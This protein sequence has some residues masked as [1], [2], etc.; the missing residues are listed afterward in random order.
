MEGD[1]LISKHIVLP[2]LINGV[3]TSALYDPGSNASFISASFARKHHITAIPLEKPKRIGFADGD[4]PGTQVQAKAIVRL[5]IGEGE[6]VHDEILTAFIFDIQ[7][8]LILGLPWSETHRPEVNWE[9]HGLKLCSER[10]TKHCHKRSDE[11]RVEISMVSANE[12]Y[13]EDPEPGT[14]LLYLYGYEWVPQLEVN[15]ARV[16]TID[17]RGKWSSPLD[18]NA[19]KVRVHAATTKEDYD[20]FMHGKPGANVLEKLPACYHDLADAFSKKDANTLPPHR[21]GIDHE[22][23]LKPEGKAK[24]PFRKPYVMHNMANDAIKK[25]I[26]D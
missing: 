10:C 18:D 25:W 12:M 4:R 6:D 16:I 14:E 5:R 1:P 21:P 8:D 23:H 15:A 9:T 11:Q 7:H 24:L 22:I 3:P 2:S 13:D 19:I 26:D 17:R 20:I